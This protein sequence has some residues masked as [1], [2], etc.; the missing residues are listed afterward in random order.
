VAARNPF[1][2]LIIGGGPAGIS[3]A[4]FLAHAAPELRPR[5]LVIEKDR[6]P[7]EKY[8]AGA[9]GAR[10]ERILAAIG[11]TVDVPGVPIGG[12]ALRALGETRVVRE[13]DV[14][15][16]VRRI[17]FD[18]ALAVAAKKRGIAVRDSVRATSVEVSP[19]GVTVRTDQGELRADV[20]VGADGVTSLVRRAMGIEASPY[21]AQAL[22]VDT[23]PVPGD[24]PR[25]VLFF[26]LSRRDLR[27]YYWDFPTVVGGRALVCRG[28]YALKPRERH[29]AKEIEQILAEELA[30]RGLELGAFRKKRYAERG[31][32]PASVV[33]SPRLLLVG[34]ALGIDPVTGEG[35]AQAIQYGAA[36]GQYL[37]R[38]LRSG[39]VV[40]EDWKSAM[41]RA[42]VGRDLLIRTGTVGLAYGAHR[43]AIER[44]VLDTPEF[45][46]VGLGHF[47]GKPWSKRA[48]ARLAL[49][50]T[51]ATA[52]KLFPG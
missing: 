48:L 7:R 21:V 45:L 33:S 4:L 8:C 52:R 17:E 46:T 49:S 22:E 6:Y 31:F 30:K 10:G 16:V 13:P 15:R 28:V 42:A 2:C 5:I 34:E 24:L 50:A 20:V 26:D 27:G 35:I 19:G 51:R 36:A 47:G 39:D 43:P 14:G 29:E 11:V 12:I 37:A 32:F 25:D 9:V 23:E 3:T 1:S 41:R 18:H 40:L 38:K 44:F